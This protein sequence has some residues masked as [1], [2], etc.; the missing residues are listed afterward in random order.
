MSSIY[1][2]SSRVLKHPTLENCLSD[3]LVKIKMECEKLA[4]M[5]NN[6]S[7]NSP[8]TPHYFSHSKRKILP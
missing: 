4:M 3:E 5:L 2:G 8:R 6:T 1:V 7:S